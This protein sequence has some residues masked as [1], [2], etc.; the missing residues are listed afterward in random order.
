M[1]TNKDLCRESTGIKTVSERTSPFDPSSDLQ[2]KL[3]ESSGE[4]SKEH[5][6]ESYPLSAG[7][8]QKD[9]EELPKNAVR[10]TIYLK[11]EEFERVLQILD[12][13]GV[14]SFSK[15]VRTQMQELIRNEV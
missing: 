14:K 2:R 6:R 11:R 1:S 13:R 10:T 15:W 7:Q 4:R 5:I 9:E 12:H 8:Q 3:Q